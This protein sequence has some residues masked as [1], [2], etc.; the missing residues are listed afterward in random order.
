MMVFE[1]EQLRS[2]SRI[3]QAAQTVAGDFEATVASARS[4]DFVY[5]DPPYTLAHT[6]N[7]FVRY[8]TRLF[9]WDDQRRLADCAA[10]L[11]GG[12]V[13]VIV[14]NAP[15]RSIMKLYPGFDRVRLM[16][17]SQIAANS[18]FRGP[19]TELVLTANV[20]HGLSGVNGER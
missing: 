15:H 1:E 20:T 13:A 5:L 14:T 12:G 3:L 16:R 2:A 7:G 18:A 10:R 4:G 11:A 19:V 8:N 9:S 17:P 6:N